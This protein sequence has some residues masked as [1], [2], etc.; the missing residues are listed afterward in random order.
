MA[1]AAEL[2]MQTFKVNI[3]NELMQDEHFDAEAVI[4]R[5]AKRWVADRRKALR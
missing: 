5:A 4:A 2:G 1:T 3:V